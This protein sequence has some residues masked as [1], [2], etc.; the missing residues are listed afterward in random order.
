MPAI[1]HSVK[2]LRQ[3]QTESYPIRL[4]DRSG[5]DEKTIRD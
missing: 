1:S 2:S 3:R 5:N 4:Q